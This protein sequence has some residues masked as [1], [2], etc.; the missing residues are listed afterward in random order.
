MCCGPWDHKES[1]TTEWLKNNNKIN[2]VVQK[3]FHI[4]SVLFLPQSIWYNHIMLPMRMD[5][6]WK[7]RASERL[8]SAHN[9]F[10]VIIWKWA[11]ALSLCNSFFYPC[12]DQSSECH[13][14]ADYSFPLFP[15]L[16]CK[17]LQPRV[18]LFLL[19][20]FLTISQARHKKMR[21]Q[22]CWYFWISSY[23]LIF[24]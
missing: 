23:S 19:F 9:S 2:T 15:W 17:D 24:L 6:A 8:F 1:D 12:K 14:T 11:L 18:P 7:R 13:F 3:S 16:H 5:F 20:L 21:C 10:C 22:F 4:A